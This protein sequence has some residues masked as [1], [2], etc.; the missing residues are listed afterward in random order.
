[1]QKSRSA[2]RQACKQKTGK[3]I[4]LA[5]LGVL[6]TRRVV[7][8]DGEGQAEKEDALRYRV[9]E[10]E[11]AVI[12]ALQS[13]Y[14]Q[15]TAGSCVICGKVD[16]IHEKQSSNYFD[17]LMFT[18]LYSIKVHNFFYISCCS[19]NFSIVAQNSNHSIPIFLPIL[20]EF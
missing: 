12:A 7:R 16:G 5:K 17:T 19:R 14:I 18:D 13:N 10:A 11:A 3:W 2:W 8:G 9:A 20:G 1:M 15:S 4:K 6:S